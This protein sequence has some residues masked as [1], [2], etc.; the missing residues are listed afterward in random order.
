VEQDKK[1]LAERESL[2]FNANLDHHLSN[3]SN[4]EAELLVILYVP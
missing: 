4:K 1:K 3:P 2:R